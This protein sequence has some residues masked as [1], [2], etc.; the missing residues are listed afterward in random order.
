MHPEKNGRNG[1]EGGKK[2]AKRRGWEI[3]ME[4]DI[5]STKYITLKYLNH[6]TKK[7]PDCLLEPI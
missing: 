7:I 1:S 6:P 4:Q 5:R 2:V 3:V